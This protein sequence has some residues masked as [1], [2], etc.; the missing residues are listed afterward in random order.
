MALTIDEIIAGVNEIIG[1]DK[2]KAKEL[3]N[4]LRERS[5]PLAQHL[6][7]VGSAL[8]K[9]ET[10]AEIERLKGELATATEARDEAVTALEGERGKAPDAAKVKE[11]LDAKWSKKVDDLKKQIASK[12][13]T[14]RGALKKG[15]LAKFTAEL[16]ANGAD[17]EWAEQIGATKYGNLIE[18]R[19]DGSVA[20]KSPDGL[21]YDGDESAK[22]KAFSGDVGKLVP[23]KFR[24]TNADSGGGANNRG[25]GTTYD[26]AKVGTEMGKA[27]KAAATDNRL[28]FT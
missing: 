19:D 16:V 23:P 22:I 15:T 6:I 4:A 25:S 7:N 3:G 17:P 27:E 28:A 26:A 5:K 8:K 2:E 13:E 24:L 1:D 9:E 21:E 10:K 12:D 18:V 11:E 20:I 14:L